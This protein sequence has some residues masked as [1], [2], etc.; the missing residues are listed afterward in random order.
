MYLFDETLFAHIRGVLFQSKFLEGA[1]KD[2]AARL[3]S[4][5]SPDL[6]A[7]NLYRSKRGVKIQPR[8]GFGSLSLHKNLLEKLAASGADI[9]PLTIDSHTRQNDYKTL[10]QIIANSLT[11]DAATKTLNGFPLIHH[12][13]K[14]ICQIHQNLGKPVSL[15]HGSPDPRLLVEIAL[16]SGVFEIEGGAI[17]Y[18]LPYSRDY[19]IEN[20]FRNWAYVDFLSGSLSISGKKIHRESFGPLTA[21]LV[22]PFMVIVIQ[23]LELLLALSQGVRSFSMS[24]GQLGSI[25]QDYATARALR[26]VAKHFVEK[27]GFNLDEPLRLVFHQW[28]GAFPSHPSRAQMLMSLGCL[29]AKFCAADKMI[30]KTVA[31]AMSLPTVEENADAVE[32]STYFLH[33]LGELKIAI[34]DKMEEETSLLAEQS[35]YV[36]DHIIHDKNKLANDVIQAIYQGKIDIPFSPHYA[37]AGALWAEH[38]S[39]NF[40][41]VVDFGKVPA[42]KKFKA[43]ENSSMRSKK[44]RNSPD[45]ILNDIN[46]MLS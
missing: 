34:D 6:F 35:M 30:T 37:N 36:L 21:T 10:E 44:L 32:Q 40:V 31:E 3:I 27:F 16:L 26:M 1:Q 4:R 24:F 17:S 39:N 2:S 12:G 18:T 41:R 5:A 11:D 33:H 9:L 14:D 43:H 42:L 23:V 19:P 15:R 20:A 28:M 38:D 13:W 22:P 46:V 29:S 7:S 45:A 8:G 25:K